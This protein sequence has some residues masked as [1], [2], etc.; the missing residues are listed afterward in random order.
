MHPE[1][2]DKVRINGF[3]GVGVIVEILP[4]ATAYDGTYTPVRVRMPSWRDAER[5]VLTV[6]LEN[7]TVVKKWKVDMTQSDGYYV[8]E[9]DATPK[10][11]HRLANLLRR[12]DLDKLKPTGGTIIRLRYNVADNSSLAFFRL[13]CEA[14]AKAGIIGGLG[15]DQAT[16]SEWASEK[17]VTICSTDLPNVLKKM[18]AACVREEQVTG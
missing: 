8:I 16:L 1:L 12:V 10:K 18:I 5:P 14:M 3:D 6:R 9:I 13:L 17:A 15:E 4:E 11:L 7:C 2:Y